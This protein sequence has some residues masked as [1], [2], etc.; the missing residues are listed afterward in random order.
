MFGWIKWVAAPV[1]AMG[2]MLGTAA[3]TSRA[4]EGTTGKGTITGVVNDA[5]GKAVAGANVRVVAPTEGA[6][7]GKNNASVSPIELAKKGEGKHGAK[8]D[9]HPA[10]AEGITDADGKFTLSNVPAG[11]YVV[12]AHLKG[13]G[14]G[15]TDVTVEDGKTAS[16]TITL[17]PEAPKK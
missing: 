14:Q 1:A 13:T 15:H 7:K 9:K 2:F 11:S 4:E 16:V 6:N 8:G 17:Q 12:H 3:L 10:V 5:N